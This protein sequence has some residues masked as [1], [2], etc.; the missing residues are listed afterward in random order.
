[1]GAT[2]QLDTSARPGDWFAL[3]VRFEG[4][5]TLISNPIYVVP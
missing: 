3:V 1:V 5:P 4:D 2:N